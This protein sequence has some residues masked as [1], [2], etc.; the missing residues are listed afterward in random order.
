[1]VDHSAETLK[2]LIEAE[3]ALRSIEA[4]FATL[5]ITNDAL[6]E[7]EA[8]VE[9]LGE[10]H[11]GND[12]EYLLDLARQFDTHIEDAAG[13]P[14]L[15]GLIV[16]LAAFDASGAPARSGPFAQTRPSADRASR[17]TETSSPPSGPETPTWSNERSDVTPWPRPNCCSTKSTTRPAHEGRR[18]TWR[19]AAAHRPGRRRH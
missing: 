7:M 15:R 17:T 8:I 1:V 6:A 19:D 16:N 4:R 11:A 3:V 12:S 18:R 14:V 2:E 10:M 5:K 9:A 13:N